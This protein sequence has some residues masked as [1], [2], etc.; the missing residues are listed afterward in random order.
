MVLHGLMLK[1]DLSYSGDP[2]I[3]AN[4][5]PELKKTKENGIFPPLPTLEEINLNR[6]RVAIIDRIDSREQKTRKIIL[7]ERKPRNIK[8]QK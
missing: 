5:R 7:P 4:M 8:S 3:R 2:S 6:T 1:E